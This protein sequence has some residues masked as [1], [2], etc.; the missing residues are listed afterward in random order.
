MAMDANPIDSL[1]KLRTVS[2]ED[3]NADKSKSER[4]DLIIK[5]LDMLTTEVLMLKAMINRL[6]KPSAPPYHPN[7]LPS[8]GPAA[9]FGQK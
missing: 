6:L 4:D 1:S 8:Q 3:H 2:H 5:K 7:P 9:F